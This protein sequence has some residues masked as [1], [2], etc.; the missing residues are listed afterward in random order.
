VL[1]GNRIREA[2]QA[3][4]FHTEL[5]KLNVTLSVGIATYPKDANDSST[6][7]EAADKAL[8]AA[9]H[10]GRNQVCTAPR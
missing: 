4:V 7:F 2:L 6:L 1:L 3:E 8:Y 10:G 9:K 5:G